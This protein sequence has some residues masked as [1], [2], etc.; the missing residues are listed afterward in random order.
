MKAEELKP[1]KIVTDGKGRIG[2]IEDVMVRKSLIG[3]CNVIWSGNSALVRE[4]CQDL[5]PATVRIITE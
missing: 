2:I 5:T 4:W 1:G 3:S